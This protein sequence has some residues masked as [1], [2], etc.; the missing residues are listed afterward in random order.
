MK[1]EEGYSWLQALGVARVFLESYRVRR[2]PEDLD[3]RFGPPEEFFTLDSSS[4]SDYDEGGRLVALLDDGNFDA[5]LFFDRLRG[6]FVL[7]DVEIPSR[8]QRRFASW[9]QYLATLVRDLWEAERSDAAL[10]RVAEL[11][12]FSHLPATISLL[13]RVNESSDSEREAAWQAFI[14]GLIEG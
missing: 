12:G 9:Q 2:L 3:N 10:G 6:D 4:Q 5:I 13:E 14:D 11:I 7:K 8:V 1:R